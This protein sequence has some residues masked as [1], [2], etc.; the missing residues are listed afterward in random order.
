MNS[1]AKGCRAERAWRDELR[2]AGYTDARRGQQYAGGTDSADVVNG[3]EGWH[4]EVK[5]V[6]ALNVRAAM[7]QA[8]RDAGSKKPYVAWKRNNKPWLIILRSE[9]F[10]DLV[11]PPET[12]P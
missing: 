5:H 11:K 8:K 7:D 4:A 2:A 9:D 12:T 3:P 1:R 10:L 6:E